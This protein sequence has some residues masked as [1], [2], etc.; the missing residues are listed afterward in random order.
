VADEVDGL[1][2]FLELGDEPIDV[3]FLRRR[4]A[5]GARVA[6]AGTGDGDRVLATERFAYAVPEMMGFGDAV[7]TGRLVFGQRRILRL[8]VNSA[9]YPSYP[10]RNEPTSEG[11]PAVPKSTRPLRD[12][13]VG[14]A[15]GNLMYR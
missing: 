2:D 9:A 11:R 15:V 4:E 5:G 10:P 8:Y 13:R 1:A 7:E 12:R 3:G 14:L 6:E